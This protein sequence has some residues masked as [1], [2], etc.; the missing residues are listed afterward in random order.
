MPTNKV[1][2]CASYLGLSFEYH[3]IDLSSGEHQSPDYLNINPAGRV[4]AIVDGDFKLS[5]SDAICRYLCAQAGDTDFFPTDT[6]KQAIVNQWIDYASQHVLQ[7]MARIFFNRVVAPLLK[8]KSDEASVK[9]GMAML[10]RDLAFVEEQLAS[11]TYLAGDHLTLADISLII[12]LEPARMCKFDLSPYP[13]ITAWFKA[14]MAQDFYTHVHTHFGAEL[15][16]RS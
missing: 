13:A 16:P 9:T 5:Q 1:R 12:A 10:G 6:K 14:I 11:H 15:P 2:L 8:Q 7:G 3:N 4:P